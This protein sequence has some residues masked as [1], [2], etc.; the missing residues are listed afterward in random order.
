[1][2]SQISIAVLPGDGIGQEVVGQALKALDAVS[3]SLEIPLETTLYSGG[4]QYYLETGKQWENDTFEQCRQ[5][6]AI[7]FGAVGLPGVY[8]EDGR[9]AGADVLFGLR[10]GLDLYANVRPVKLLPGVQHIFAGKKRVVWPQDAVDLVV[11]RENTEGLYTTDTPLVVKG[12]TRIDKRKIT[13]KGSER[14]IRTAFELAV[15]RSHERGDGT[16]AR[17]TCVDKKNLL[18]GCVL[19]NSV[20]ERI[21]YLYSTVQTD[22]LHIDAATLAVLQDPGKYDVLVTTN[23]FGDILSDLTSV[24]GGGLG[25]AP[26]ANIGD[27]HGMFEPVHGTAPTLAG[28]DLANPLGA[29]LSAGMMLGWLGDRK[30]DWRFKLG[31]SIIENA[32]ADVTSRGIKTR[33]IGGR[34]KCSTVGDA[35][36]RR[37]PRLIQ[38]N[39][40]E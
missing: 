29:I 28:K 26:S 19:F 11:V 20:F 37:I 13:R 31:A 17:V 36:Q 24:L 22:H 8:L 1:M 5:A 25:T 33:D 34:A 15:R 21:A 32:V 16:L 35:V 27:S 6:D 39:K 3:Q 12:H 38:K 14:I 18:A 7:L 23:L 9:P 2:D 30:H 4:A 10:K 40:G